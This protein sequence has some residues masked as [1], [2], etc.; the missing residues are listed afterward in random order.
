MAST[1]K[2]LLTPDP[3]WTSWEKMFFVVCGT[4]DVATSAWKQ[5][6]LGC[7]PME[8]PNFLSWAS[9]R[10]GLASLARP[11]TPA[12]SSSLGKGVACW[13]DQQRGNL[14]YSAPVL[15]K[16][17]STRLMR[18]QTSSQWT[19]GRSFS[20]FSPGSVVDATISCSYTWT[21]PGVF[22]SPCV[23]RSPRKSRT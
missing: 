22:P 18:M 2:P 7:M 1:A 17:M 13:D 9:F 20:N 15:R 11:R 23:R 10:S 3:V 16:G 6:S 5:A 12:S 21:R 19:C 4:M 8:T 14:H